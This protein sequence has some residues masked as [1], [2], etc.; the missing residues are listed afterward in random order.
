M[1]EVRRTIGQA[2]SIPKNEVYLIWAGKGL[3]A[4]DS[5]GDLLIGDVRTVRFV[6]I[7]SAW[8]EP[9]LLIQALDG[10]HP[11]AEDIIAGKPEPPVK[12]TARALLHDRGF[13]RV[14]VQECGSA[15]RLA[16]E[17]LQHDREIVLLAVNED[18][19]ALGYAAEPLRDDHEV[20][21]TAVRRTGAALEYAS[22]ALRGDYEVI[23]A[24][25]HENGDAIRFATDEMRRNRA[26]GLAA[27]QQRGSALR[28]LHFMLQEDHTFVQA[29]TRLNGDAYHHALSNLK[30]RETAVGASA[31]WA[32]E[33]DAPV[34][35]RQQAEPFVHLAEE[36]CARKQR[37]V[38]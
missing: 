10:L 15:L 17:A 21:L 2:L 33:G 29:A 34:S 25:V 16:A 6:R 11:N 14:A 9:L 37:I 30:D 32:G 13:V 4:N 35:F 31:F 20:V 12:R 36:R 7:E 3:G 18:G 19:T 5:A 38:A 24:A 28:H 8:R 26:L 1:R 23:E 27:V 22:K